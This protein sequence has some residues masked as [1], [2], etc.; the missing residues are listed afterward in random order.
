MLQ[1]QRSERHEEAPVEATQNSEEKKGMLDRLSHFFNPKKRRSKSSQISD[2]S[3]SASCPGSP[4]SP[5]SP[6]SPS[7]QQ[8]DGLKTPTPSRKDGKPAETDLQAGME[9]LSQSSSPSVSSLSTGEGDFP[10]ADSISSSRSSVREVPVSRVN[11][12]G[13]QRNSGNVTP[14]V[15]DFATTTLPCADSSSEVGFTESVVEEVSKRLQMNLEEITVKNAEGL[16]H[17]PT[18]KIKD[19]TPKS[20]NLTSITLGTNKTKVTFGEKSHSMTLQGITLG[21]QSSTPQLISGSQDAGSENSVQSPSLEKDQVPP[22]DSPVK[23]YNAMLVEVY[24]EEVEKKEREEMSK[25]DRTKKGEEEGSIPL[26]PPVLAIPVTVF[27][28][29]ES[30]TQED[31]NSPSTPSQTSLPARTLP[32]L[33]IS[34]TSTP[35]DLQ[36]TLNQSDEPDTGTDSKKHPFKD[37][38]KSKGACVTRKTVNLPS[39]SKDVA[40]VASVSPEL[41]LHPDKQAGEDNSTHSASKTSEPTKA[42]RLQHLQN[43]NEESRHADVPSFAPTDESA[44][45]NTPGHLVKEKTD[46]E[47][48]DFEDTSATPD[49]HRAKSQHVA[50][51]I[52]GHAANQAT[53][54]KPGDKVAVV[55]QRATGSVARPLATAAGGKA[56]NVTTKAKGSTEDIK[57]AASS[58]IP[59]L[60]Q[61]SN[62][63]TVSVITPLKDKCTT[64]L[65]KSKIPQRQI[66]DSDIKAVSAEKTPVAHDST[67]TSKLQKI[68]RTASESLKSLVSTTKG[69]QK[70][71]SDEANRV[72][73]QSGDREHLM[74]EKT[75][76]DVIIEH[77]ECVNLVNGLEEH[78]EENIK[79]GRPL[80]GQNLDSKKNDKHT[81]LISKSRLPVS[82]PTRKLNNDVPK[83]SEA[84]HRKVTSPQADSDRNKQAQKCPEQQEPARVERPTSETPSPSGSPKKGIPSLKPLR[85]ISKTSLSID[86]NDTPIVTNQDKED[87]NHK[88]KHLKIPSNTSVPSSPSKLPTRSQRGSNNVRSKQLQNTPTDNLPNTESVVKPT[89]S[90]VTS[91]LEGSATDGACDVKSVSQNEKPSETMACK[92]DTSETKEK[93]AEVQEAEEAPSSPKGNISK[94]VILDNKKTIVEVKLENKGK[95]LKAVT[96][97]VSLVKEACGAKTNGQIEAHDVPQQPIL[98]TS[99][100]NVPCHLQGDSYTLELQTPEMSKNVK[101]KGLISVT[102][103]L[104]TNTEVDFN[105]EKGASEPQPVKPVL[106]DIIQCDSITTSH[107]EGG[108]VQPSVTVTSKENANVCPMESASKGHQSVLTTPSISL[109]TPNKMQNCELFEKQVPENNMSLSALAICSIKNTAR[110]EKSKE[111]VHQKSAATTHTDTKAVSEAPK[112]VECHL[113]KEPLLQAEESEREKKESKSSEKLNDASLLPNDSSGE[114]KSLSTDNDAKKP[115]ES[116]NVTSDQVNL[117]PASEEKTQTVNT[118]KEKKSESQKQNKIS[119]VVCDGTTKMVNSKE[120][121]EDSVKD[122]ATSEITEPLQQMKATDKEQLEPLPNAEGARSNNDHR[123]KPSHVEMKTPDL[124]KDSETKATLMKSSNGTTITQVC[125]KEDTK[126]VS[127]AAKQDQID[128]QAK[129]SNAESE[130]SNK[131]MEEVTQAKSDIMAQDGLSTSKIEHTVSDTKVEILNQEDKNMMAAQQ[132]HKQEDGDQKT[133]STKILDCL[134]DQNDEKKTKK[135]TPSS[136]LDVEHHLKHKKGNRKHPDASPSGHDELDDFI[137]STKAGGIPFSVPLKKHPR[138]KSPSPPFAMPPIMEDHFETTFDPEQFQFGLKKKGKGLKDPSPA[139]VLKQKAAQR[140]G[141]TLESPHGANNSTSSCNEEN[142]IKGKDE[143]QQGA[144][145]EQN[146]GEQPGKPTSR[147]QRI[148]ILSS[149]LSSP[150][151]SKTR[152]EKVASDP[153]DTFSSKQQHNLPSLGKQEITFPEL[154]SDRK[155]AAGRGAGAGAAAG[156]G[157]GTASESTL[158][159]AAPPLPSFPQMK[160]PDHQE[161]NLKD[162]GQSEVAQD[163]SEAPKTTQNSDGRGAMDQ[164]LMPKVSNAVLPPPSKYIS[165]TPPRKK[166]S[167]TRVERGF[168][169]RP[170]K[171][172]IHE[173]EEFGDNVYELCCDVEDATAMKLSPVIFVQVIRGCWLLYENKGFQGRVIALE[174]GQTDHIVNMWADDGAPMTMDEKGQPV[175]TTPMIIGSIRL[176]V[177]DY[178]KPRIDLFTEVN[179]LG[180]MSSY[181]DDT[182]EIGS[183]RIPQATG[184]IKVHSGVWLVYS[185]PGFGGFLGVLEVGEFPCP[186]SWGF[187]QPFVGSLRPLRIGAIRVEHPKEVK[188]LLFE[189]PN[190]EGACLEVDG[191]LYNLSEEEREEPD[192]P[193]ETKKTT[194][195]VGSLKILGGLWVGY[196]EADFEGQQ[197]ILEEGEYPHCSDWGGAE[198]GLLSLRPICTDFLSPHIKLFSEP[199]MDALGLSVDLMGPVINMEEVGQGTKTQSINVLSGVWVAFQNPGFSGELYILERGLYTCPE[200]WDAKTFQIAS[201]QPILNDTGIES[202]F[203]V[204]LFSEPNFQGKLVVLEDSMATLDEDFVTRSCKVLAGSWI[205]YEGENFTDN[206]YLLEEGEY[207]DTEF[208]GFLSSDMKVRSMQTTGHELSMPSILLFSKLGCRG[209][210]AV[211]TNGAVNLHQAGL[212]AHIRSLVVEGGKWVLYEGSNYRGRQLLLQPGQVVDWCKFSGWKGI[213]SLRPL[214]QK[215]ICIR[216]RNKETGCVMSLMGALEDIQ[217]MRVHAVED[218]DGVEQIWLYRDGQLTCKL[219]EDCCLETTGNVV[220]AGSRLCV[221]PERGKDNQL[222]NITSDGLVRSHFQP[223]LVLEVKGG[224]QY[225]KNQVILNTFEEGKPNQR[226][227]LEI[228]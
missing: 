203:K 15:L 74:K 114:L 67:A 169:Q 118:Q 53:T 179:G 176:A 56:K 13:S 133:K 120:H 69:V 7:L 228:L 227:T 147:L 122:K 86:N 30:V 216:L 189:K 134:P 123:E 215:Q 115:K 219:A 126:S 160:L 87:S 51:R 27:P 20:Q 25:E 48:S 106:G 148:S 178:S 110:E 172:F 220:M 2:T 187:P 73:A 10:F 162:G 137:R 214:L 107:Q 50:S 205:A 83:T 70:P 167:K 12:G 109:N 174:E 82:S 198:D 201:I 21:S 191:D 32:E 94:Q 186:Q 190:F 166:K 108:S 23:V 38:Q 6:Q 79:M 55:S 81:S 135:E 129:G 170:G 159:P 42:Q 222:W 138:M 90:I 158:C 31:T 33:S 196:Q 218:T 34:L 112:N 195:A 101:D 145:M 17:T 225:D 18:L 188:A 143:V 52:R 154:E 8:Q 184:S 140:E 161:K 149:L 68:A 124:T 217:L 127:E 224:H 165:K 35:R 192:S 144:K 111:E 164:A 168:H 47:T 4:A 29:D 136:W 182:V 77:P 49:M 60:K 46:S 151:S 54:S 78:Q 139:M 183:Y 39:K 14:T 119:A 152:K 61:Q 104:P 92:S 155:G 72:K 113:D 116:S 16:S 202:K 194:S 3:A 41:S 193:C 131:S 24:L 1:Q 209:R 117:L 132:N 19:S 36:T 26:S 80:D 208:M 207:P 75:K 223:D 102:A 5:L 28:E 45:S 66:S 76:D 65:T 64:G 9:T 150:R 93:G 130:P 175:S 199:N 141:R 181:Y 128:D 204:K 59:P 84:N 96:A 43:N 226:W 63:K 105:Q 88:T 206:M 91:C 212:E 89:D 121:T 97:N 153:N 173:H 197:Y 95:A 171:M 71:S 213:G 125:N 11:S 22:G 44:D 103:Q 221:S 210:R 58:D 98:E 99:S 180:R 211:L 40:H 85:N 163:L 62:G 146:N 177:K 100:K 157:N 142:E 37:K 200:D 57:V 185:D 156:S